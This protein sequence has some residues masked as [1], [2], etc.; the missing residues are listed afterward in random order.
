[1]DQDLNPA[2]PV[3]T[4]EFAAA[5]DELNK[6]PVV[7]PVPAPTP[8][9]ATVPEGTPPAATP[10]AAT[11]PAA[12]V[13]EGTPPAA[14]PPAA[15]APEGTPPV[16]A[17][18]AEPVTR[19]EYEALKA[20][21]DEAR[22]APAPTPPAPQAPAPVVEPELYTAAELATI[23]KYREDWPDIAAGEALMRKADMVAVVKHVFQQ[24]TPLLNQALE[25]SQMLVGRTQLDDLHTLIPDYDTVREPVIDWVGKQP[26]VMRAGLEQVTSKGSPEDIA[27]LVEMFK[28]AT[29]W[30]APADPAATTPAAPPVAAT[31][32]VPAPAAAAP[33][34]N[35]ALPP[36]A[37][38]AL[39]ALKPVNSKRTEPT[40]E[41]DPNDFDSAFKEFAAA[42]K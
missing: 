41:P 16:A 30:T 20:Q 5:F 21:L 22:R 14:T 4:D 38:A 23:N 24:M 37:A 42:E 35:G 25:S 26:A 15:A 27:K 34:P 13:P 29:G 39:A 8:P 10:P 19:A 32:P 6:P 18:P 1:M 7:D 11:P 33:K 9:A 28:V 2:P 12:T 40:G 17:P 36:A 3:E 31:V